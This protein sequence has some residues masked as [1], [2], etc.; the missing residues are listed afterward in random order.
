MP[1]QDAVVAITAGVPDMGAVLNLIW[2]HLLPAMQAAPLPGEPAAHDMLLRRFAGLSIRVPEGAK[3]SPV[4]A[5][6][7]GQ[8]FRFEPN[9]QEVETVTVEFRDGECLLRAQRASREEVLRCG[10]DGKWLRGTTTLSLGPRRHAIPAPI[11]V[12]ASGAWADPNTYVAKLCFHETPFCPTITCRFEG[13]SLRVDYR[14]NVAFGPTEAPP[15]FGK[16]AP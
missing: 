6:T 13:D 12:A 4:A 1:E 10:N 5:A 3:S 15:L 16:R 9:D 7:S 2:K 8:V 11:P 14:V